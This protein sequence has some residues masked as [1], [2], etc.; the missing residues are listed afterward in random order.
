MASR[1]TSQRRPDGLGIAPRVGE[2]GDG[3]VLGIADNQRDAAFRSDDDRERRLRG[4]PSGEDGLDT[5]TALAGKG[6]VRIECQRLVVVSEGAII[7]ALFLIGIAA[8]GIGASIFRIEMD[9]LIVVRDRAVVIALGR[10]DNAAVD[11][12]GSKFWIEPECLIAIG[13]RSVKLMLIV[14]SPAAAI[15]SGSEFWIEPERLIIVRDCTVGVPLAQIGKAAIIVGCGTW[16]SRNEAA[17]CGDRLVAGRFIARII[18]R[19]RRGG[20]AEE[21]SHGRP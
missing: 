14:V 4:P 8:A 2:K 17:A 20:E 9:R 13:H 15:V 19:R 16:R 6:Q 1:P 21:Q 12:G 11:V 7:L 18:G 10:I 3:A 5:L